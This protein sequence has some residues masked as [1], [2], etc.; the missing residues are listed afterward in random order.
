MTSNFYPVENRKC[1][2]TYEDYNNEEEAALSCW[3][4]I[5]CAGYYGQVPPKGYKLCKYS[6]HYNSNQFV[7][8]S[9]TDVF[10]KKGNSSKRKV[11]C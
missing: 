1:V 3:N 6:N 11:A 4:D 5:D 10:K 7:Y 9:G 2:G 8:N